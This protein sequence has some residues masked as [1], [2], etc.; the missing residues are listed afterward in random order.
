LV[1]ALAQQ[2]H[3]ATLDLG[4]IV[5]EADAKVVVELG[6]LDLRRAGRDQR[7][8]R[9]RLRRSAAGAEPER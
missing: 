4:G 6:D 8:E 7:I 1:G 5:L 2:G 3:P 9:A